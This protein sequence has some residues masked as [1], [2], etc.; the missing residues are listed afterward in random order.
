MTAQNP[1]VVFSTV[2]SASQGRTIAKAILEAQ[3]AS[4]V[5]VV[6][7]IDS[8]F[9]WR[10]KIDYACERLLMIKTDKRRLKK[11]EAMIRKLHQYEIPEIIG[12][13]IAWGSK[14]YLNWLAE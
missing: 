13:P 8:F 3:F 12:W 14:S 11:L 7:G 5:N 1:Y 4:C 10:G 2:P 6:P 9:R